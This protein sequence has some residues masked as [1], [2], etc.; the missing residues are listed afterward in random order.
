MQRTAMK[1]PDE[2]ALR[3]VHGLARALEE[4]H[5]ERFGHFGCHCQAAA[6]LIADDGPLGNLGYEVSDFFS[7]IEGVSPP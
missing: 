4:F 3:L 5:G 7:V 2:R 1:K 6:I